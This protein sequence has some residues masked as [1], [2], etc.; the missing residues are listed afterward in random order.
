MFVRSVVCLS[1]AA[2]S[3]LVI[4]SCGSSSS[5]ATSKDNNQ[6]QVP[7]PPPKTVKS[8][9][10]QPAGV[11]LQPGAQQQFS[12]S[13]SYSDGSNGDVTKEVTWNS[14]NTAVFVF[15][16]PGLGKAIAEGS[17]TI[18]ASLTKDGAT[19]QGS[20]GM[21]V[22]APPPPPPPQKVL[23]SIQIS[24]QQ[25]SLKVG[26]QKQLS[27]TAKYS[28]G[29]TSDVTGKVQWN[30]SE[31]GDVS[32]DANGLLKALAEG[33]ATVT[34]VLTTDSDEFTDSIDVTVTPAQ[35][36]PTSHVNVTTYHYNNQRTGLN[37]HETVVKPANVNRDQ[38]GKLF[39]YTVDGLIYAQPLY[40]SGLTIRG[41]AH[42]VV[43]VSTE[44]NNVYAFDA[45]NYSD[46]TPLW[47]TTLLLDGERMSPQGS[48]KPYHGSTSTPVIDPATNTMYVTTTQL[49]SNDSAYF[50][51]HA[52]DVTDGHEKASTVVD[53]SVPGAS[54]PDGIVRLSPS[55]I[56]RSALTLEAGV[57][58][59]GFSACGNGWLLA[60]DATSLTQIGVLNTSPNILGKGKYPGAGGVWMGGGGAVTGSDGYIYI[61]TGDGPYDGESAFGDTIL[62]LD[63][64]LHIVDHFTPEEYRFMQCEDQDL[65][66]G[67]A[68]LI[69]GTTYLLAGGKSGKLFMVDST[70][71]GH[72][73][74]PD[75]AGAV[76]TLYPG[77]NQTWQYDCIDPV[78]GEIITGTKAGHQIFGTG[79]WFNNSVYVGFTPGPLR[80]LNFADGR[81]SLGLV[82]NEQ[83]VYGSY[84]TSPV[85]SANGTNDGIVWMID[86]GIPLQAATNPPGQA[87]THAILRAYDAADI[88]HE[89]YDSDQNPTD[90]P[91]FGI[92]FSTPIVADGKVFVATAHD[93]L[94]VSD[95]MGELDIYG[96]K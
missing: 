83:I 24:P 27:A 88:T 91:G 22:K 26:Q 62:K 96:L 56:Q 81:L 6:N 9:T 12:A 89:L 57:I 71:L 70:N 73:P 30:A 15:E 45:D 10:V 31:D 43:F 11:S 34:A 93:T 65:S 48:I 75:N 95:A 76:Q 35:P 53:A 85:V 58:Y 61:T 64:G 77:V 54:S 32:V 84:G 86:H 46:G 37:D 18:T 39:S 3:G 94:D 69:P 1:L 59:M 79:A 14:S 21:Q 47:K 28:D 36:Q 16:S 41:T 51:L 44:K 38:F 66:G 8:V 63:R 52:L 23:M 2:L 7:P 4:I 67:G 40:V 55:C 72:G 68:L 78:T 92:K 5:A 82:A 13:A 80:Q 87:P 42:N 33:K 25:I 74:H 90:V 20:V 50:S 19:A 29:S 60:Y 49:R 17:A